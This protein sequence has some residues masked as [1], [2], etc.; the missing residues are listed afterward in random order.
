MP[1][2]MHASLALLMLALAAPGQTGP[3]ARLLPPAADAPVRR[4]QVEIPPLPDAAA[5]AAADPVWGQ[6][7]SLQ[8]AL[9]GALTGNPDLNALRNNNI[10]SPESVEVARRFPTTLNP[11]LWVDVRPFIYERV[12]GR[13]N[14]DHKDTL[15]YFSW[16]QPIE[17]GHQTT[18][19]YEIAKA[20]YS[21][22][23]WTVVQAELLALVQTFRFFQTAAYRREKLRVAQQLADFNDHL[24]QSLQR[25]FEANQV[26]AADV[27]LAK[28]ENR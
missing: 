14:P 26:R 7:I 25:R 27:S 3:H 1:V 21:Q 5:P 9:Y 16:R 17:L 2:S 22:Q 23:Q 24:L 6:S 10:A 11:T 12:P 8:A 4:A 15:M 19:R 20:A 13:A 28:V 18:H